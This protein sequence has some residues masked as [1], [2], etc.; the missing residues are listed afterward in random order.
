ME[1]LPF[2]K[3]FST[4]QRTP[5]ILILVSLTLIILGLIPLYH[6]FYRYPANLIVDHSSKITSH[7]TTTTTKYQKI[8]KQ[9]DEDTC[10]VFIGE[11]VR[12][13]DAPYYTNMTCWAI[14][15]HQNCMK[16]GRPDTDFLKWRWKPKGCDLPI[17]N[18]YQFLDMM[19]NKSMAF[20]GDSVGR[21]Q[22]QSLICLLSRVSLFKIFRRSIN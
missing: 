12:N 13:P 3:N 22:M 6:P 7:G 21:N 1:L 18:P 15:E 14:H 2:W 17:F 4:A 16:Y 5:R 9:D 20:I 11:W 8:I 10:D 19:R